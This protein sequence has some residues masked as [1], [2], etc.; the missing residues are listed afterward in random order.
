M[1]KLL[2]KSKDAR[3]PTEH[4]YRGNR[5]GRDKFNGDNKDVEPAN[6]PERPR[7]ECVTEQL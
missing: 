6:L 5:I 1:R 4:F 2:F 3:K 7:Q